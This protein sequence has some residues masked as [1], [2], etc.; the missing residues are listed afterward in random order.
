[1]FFIF[2]I[3]AGEI[4]AQEKAGS[5]EHGRA[6]QLERESASAEKNNQHQDL[7]AKSKTLAIHHHSIYFVCRK[8]LTSAIIDKNSFLEKKTFTVEEYIVIVSTNVN[9]FLEKK[10][11]DGL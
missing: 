9:S 3:I 10:N 1:M 7:A 2:F 4:S 6:D 11:F 5:C 8:L